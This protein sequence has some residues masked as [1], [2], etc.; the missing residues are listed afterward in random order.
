MDQWVRGGKRRLRRFYLRKS[1]TIHDSVIVLTVTEPTIP[2][3]SVRMEQKTTYIFTGFYNSPRP[4]VRQT[5]ELGLYAARLWASGDERKMDHAYDMWQRL[6]IKLEK[7][8]TYKERMLK[9]K[10]GL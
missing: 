8:Q 2:Y 3:D 7:I 5:D 6:G 10:F 9:Q 1:V 4:S